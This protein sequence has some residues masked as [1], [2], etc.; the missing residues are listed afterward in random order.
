MHG[1]D[2]HNTVLFDSAAV[3]VRCCIT[4]ALAVVV[5]AGAGA[6]LNISVRRCCV[7]CLC[8]VS[9]LFLDEIQ[10]RAVCCSR[11]QVH[12]SRPAVKCSASCHISQPICI[13]LHVILRHRLQN[14]A[15]QW[16]GTQHVI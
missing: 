1:V 7:L 2:A 5:T 8:F 12:S 3:G 14:V 4:W 13:R 10:G 6:H 15:G 11:T 16:L 9:E